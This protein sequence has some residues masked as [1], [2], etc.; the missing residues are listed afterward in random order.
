MCAF[1]LFPPKGK[2]HN[3]M[4]KQTKIN[5][6]ENIIYFFLS[7]VSVCMWGQASRDHNM[8][9][10]NTKTFE[11]VTQ[12]DRGWTLHRQPVLSNVT[13]RVCDDRI[14]RLLFFCPLSRLL[15]PT[16]MRT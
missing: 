14:A 4:L 8:F 16:Y 6:T 5:N 12:I 11:G 15:S 7:E 2:L 1:A 13:I 9:V 3:M 10:C